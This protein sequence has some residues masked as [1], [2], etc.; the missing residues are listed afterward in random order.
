MYIYKGVFECVFVG[1]FCVFWPE[2]AVC[3]ELKA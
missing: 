3:E 2:S 1:T